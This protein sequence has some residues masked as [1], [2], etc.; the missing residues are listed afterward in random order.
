MNA[1]FF[2]PDKMT[3]CSQIITLV[4]NFLHKVIKS[5]SISL[6]ERIGPI[7]GPGVCY[8]SAKWRNLWKQQNHP[9]L[10]EVHYDSQAFQNVFKAQ[11]LGKVIHWMA[12]S[13]EI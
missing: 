4:S 12:R 7:W 1:L 6:Y 11:H 9:M 13:P 3:K 10:S 2:F 5:K 8:F